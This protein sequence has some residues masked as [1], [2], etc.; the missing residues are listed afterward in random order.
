MLAAVV[1]YL[2]TVGN[3]KGFAF[4]LGLTTI[5]DLAVVVL[6]THPVLQLLAQ[7]KF[8]S[9][10]NRWSGFDSK[11]LGGTVYRGRMQFATSSAVSE[12]KLA[13]A[14][15]EANKRQTLAER[16]AAEGDK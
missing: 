6:F 13:K 9:S 5:I 7:T 15:K 14:N 10:G 4:T 8:F 2:L 3:V 16:K 11:A 1:L 12:G